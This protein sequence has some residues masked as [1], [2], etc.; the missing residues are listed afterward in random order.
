MTIAGRAAETTPATA[1]PSR[2]EHGR[3]TKSTGDGDNPNNLLALAVAA[4]RA[5]CSVGEISD[6]LESVWGRH[7][8]RNDVVRGAY[9]FVDRAR[10]KT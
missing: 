3:A 5:H 6:A 10:P 7:E 1:I 9:L 4:A 2:C 8:P